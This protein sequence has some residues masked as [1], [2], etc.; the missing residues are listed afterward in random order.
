MLY[1]LKE[2]KNMK[3]SLFFLKIKEEE[4]E[5]CRDENNK[6]NMKME[7]RKKKDKTAHQKRRKNNTGQISQS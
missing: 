4:V 1:P 6:K 2:P 7:N 3:K 5:K